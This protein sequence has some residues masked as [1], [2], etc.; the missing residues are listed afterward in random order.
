MCVP[1]TAVVAHTPGQL[2]P[3]VLSDKEQSLIL[4]LSQQAWVNKLRSEKKADALL[5]LAH[6][7][8]EELDVPITTVQAKPFLAS[9]LQI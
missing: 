1:A 9:V 3:T 4:L 8:H 7:L 2:R 6:L 5:W